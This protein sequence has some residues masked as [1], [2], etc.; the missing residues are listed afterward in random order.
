LYERLLTRVRDASRG[1]L[2]AALVQAAPD[3]PGELRELVRAY[4]DVQVWESLVGETRRTG[5]VTLPA[6]SAG[7][8]KKT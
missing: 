8:P 6:R 1:T 7:R 2:L 3:D 5:K 4:E